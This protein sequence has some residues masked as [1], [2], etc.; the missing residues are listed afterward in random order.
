MRTQLEASTT[1]GATVIFD[2]DDNGYVESVGGFGGHQLH[3]LGHGW[4][5]QP[6]HHSFV[7]PQD[8]IAEANID[9]LRTAMLDK[10]RCCSQL[11]FSAEYLH[12]ALSGAEEFHALTSPLDPVTIWVEADQVFSVIAAKTRRAPAWSAEELSALLA[13]AATHHGCSIE[14]VRYDS[15]GGDPYEWEELP[16]NSEELELL[17]QVSRDAPHEVHIRVIAEDAVVVRDLVAAGRAVKALLE[18][19][20]GGALNVETVRNLLRGGHP[21]LLIGLSECDWFEAKSQAYNLDAPGSAGERQKIELA[22]DVA[23]FANGDTEAILVVGLREGTVPKQHAVAEV[24]PVLLDAVDTQRYRAILDTRII[25]P[26][27]GLV[28]ETVELEAGTGLLLISVPRQLAELQPFLVHGAIVGD[29][30]E[31]AFFS[32]VRRRGEGSI[33]TTAAQIHAYIVAGRAFLRS[34]QS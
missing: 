25:P 11:P 6:K 17:K 4:I 23:R 32:I 34:Q 5:V 27:A 33:T 20:Q 24:K 1:E 28:L 15:H 30:V 19:Y 22:Q 26:V 3:V 10:R 13:P 31:G 18:A 14:R 29:K 2:P 21:S 7:A 12:I 9:S 8:V 16:V